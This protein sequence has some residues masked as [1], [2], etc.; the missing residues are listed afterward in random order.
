MCINEITFTHWDLDFSCG[1]GM[2]SGLP[3]T[4]HTS[5][6]KKWTSLALLSQ[7]GQRVVLN[8]LI[9]K[10]PCSL[11]IKSEPRSLLTCLVAGLCPCR[12]AWQINDLTHQAVSAARLQTYRNS[13]DLA[14]LCGLS[15][16]LV[17]TSVVPWLLGPSVPGF[18]RCQVHSAVYVGLWQL[19][20]GINTL[21]ME[22]TLAHHKE[23]LMA[24]LRKHYFVTSG[25]SPWSLSSQR[26]VVK[27]IF[28]RV[29]RGPGVPWNSMERFLYAFVYSSGKINS[30]SFNFQGISG[31]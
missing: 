8:C 28:G 24:P 20:H 10:A 13:S 12:R 9:P 21:H 22:K 4:F 27:Q 11:G 16:N 19:L 17:F 18:L 14:D 2:D 15:S 5:V 30:H 29:I 1:S 31:R 25:N 6:F 7:P 3:V 23:P 26:C